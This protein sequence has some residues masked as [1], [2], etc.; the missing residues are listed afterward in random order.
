MKEKKPAQFKIVILQKKQLAVGALLI[1]AGFFMPLLVNQNL[2]PVMRYFRLA[3]HEERHLLIASALLLA[4]MNIIRA[5]PHYIGVYWV[6]DS[7]QLQY[8]GKRLANINGLL[9]VVL[10]L[11]TYFLIDVINGIHYDF[12]LPAIIMTGILV[13][14]DHLQYNYVSLRK[15]TLLV[16]VSLM[17]LQFLDIMPA[18]GVLPVGR[19]EISRDIKRAAELL[20]LQEELNLAALIGFSALVLIAV[21]IFILVRDENRLREASELREANN[22]IQMEAFELEVQN[23]TL[24]E[25]QY[26][27][28]D[29][30]SPLSVVQT[31]EG[32]LRFQSIESGREETETYDRMEKALDQMSTRISQLLTL[33]QRDSFTVEELLHDVMA[34]IS[35]ESYAPHVGA[36]TGIPEAV[37]YA[38]QGL[39]SRALVNLVRNAVQAVPPER[40]PRVEVEAR[41]EKGCIVLQV[42]DN[43]KGVAPGMQEKIWT[44]GVSGK[45]SSGLGLAFVKSAVERFG[46]QVKMESEEGKGTTIALW[47]PEEEEAND[48]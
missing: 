8:K 12:G 41:R 23:R 26:L 14:Y 1:V 27:V 31:L 39:L 45:G 9:I 32:V 29:L 13:L 6:T 19:G 47:I 15:R 4:L 28:H 40:I 2:I 20:E 35:I 36:D 17:S 5:L 33:D 44:H 42:T 16:A 48:K 21:M 24:R 3:M 30:K 7:I 43:G 25:T 38:N 18:A 22:R 46:G 34:Q 37:L 11:L 10:L